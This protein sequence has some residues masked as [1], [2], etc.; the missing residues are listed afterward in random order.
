MPEQPIQFAHYERPIANTLSLAS[1]E[2]ELADALHGLSELAASAHEEGVADDQNAAFMLIYSVCLNE[3][4]DLLFDVASGRGRQ[5]LRG[6]R[7]LFEVQLAA[8]DVADD[9]TTAD[10]F[11]AHRLQSEVIARRLVGEDVG[12]GFRRLAE[13][14]AESGSTHGDLS[15]GWARGSIRQRAIRHGLV[16]Q[17][18]DFYGIASNMVHAT[19]LTIS[20]GLVTTEDGWTSIAL[21]ANTLGLRLAFDRGME[22]TARTLAALG[23]GPHGI[24]LAHAIETVRDEVSA[25]VSRF[26]RTLRLESA[27]QAWH[28]SSNLVLVVRITSNSEAT[29]EWYAIDVVDDTYAAVMRPIPISVECA[30]AIDRARSVVGAHGANVRTFAFLDSTAGVVTPEN[31]EW[32]P[33]GGA[34]F[35]DLNGRVAPLLDEAKRRLAEFDL[36]V[37]DDERALD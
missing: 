14:A 21:G 23:T 6:A 26:E 33:M 17:Y 19:G 16:D 7:A 13:L 11:V 24:A 22:Y 2:A 35:A 27:R 30:Q 20:G 36:V 28:Y 29:D 5:A 32:Y 4:V 10:R 18:D 31:R 12:N 25:R 9:E 34:P 8:F 15:R 1:T 3:F 37:D